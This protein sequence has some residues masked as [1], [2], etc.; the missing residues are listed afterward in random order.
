MEKERKKEKN[1]YRQYVI[2]ILVKGFILE[3]IRRRL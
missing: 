1:K 2:D 3:E